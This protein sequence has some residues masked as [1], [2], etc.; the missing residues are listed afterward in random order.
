MNLQELDSHGSASCCACLVKPAMVICCSSSTY[1]KWK[2]GHPRPFANPAATAIAWLPVNVWV[3]R[4]LLVP[5]CSWL[6]RAH[7][8]IREKLA[9]ASTGMLQERVTLGDKRAMRLFH[10]VLASLTCCVPPAA[11]CIGLLLSPA[12]R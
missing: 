11:S 3:F 8:E 1:A 7:F 2:P 6:F 9:T 5:M 10:A 12:W 4:S